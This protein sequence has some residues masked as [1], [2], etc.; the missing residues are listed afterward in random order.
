EAVGCN[1]VIKQALDVEIGIVA[2]DI[3][4]C[5]DESGV[6]V[7]QESGLRPCRRWTDQDHA[8]CDR[9]FAFAIIHNSLEHL[10]QFS[11]YRASVSVCHVFSQ[12]NCSDLKSESADDVTNDL[13]CTNARSVCFRYRRIEPCICTVPS[14]DSRDFF[15]PFPLRDHFCN[16][17]CEDR[18]DI[19]LVA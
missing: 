8:V 11:M 12:S 2:V 19:P 15:G 13:R 4:W 17:A 6:G 5:A 9:H 10:T 14:Y 1:A 18:A 7:E 16:V 3:A